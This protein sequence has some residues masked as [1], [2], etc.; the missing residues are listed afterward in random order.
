MARRM[1][2]IGLFLLLF[3]ASALGVDIG[4]LG[5]GVTGRWTVTISTPGRKILG[6]AELTQSGNAVT[7]WLELNDGHRV[8][9][10]GALLGG[11]LVITTHPESRQHFAFDRCELKAGGN[12][13][14]GKIYPAAGKIEFWKVRETRVLPRPRDW[15]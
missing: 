8:P 2:F 5:S 6:E 11:G 12:H 9:L 15:H 4:G 13:M 14:K 3:T 10:S 7:G 1:K